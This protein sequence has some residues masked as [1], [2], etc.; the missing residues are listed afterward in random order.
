MEYKF[1]VN[2]KNVLFATQVGGY[3][4]DLEEFAYLAQKE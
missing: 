4:M 1:K 2:Q 3:I